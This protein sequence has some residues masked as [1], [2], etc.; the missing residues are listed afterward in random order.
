MHHWAEHRAIVDF[1]KCERRIS[2]RE[3]EDNAGQCDNCVLED[4]GTAMIYD[5]EE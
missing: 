2:E 3:H 4:T 1:K 5:L